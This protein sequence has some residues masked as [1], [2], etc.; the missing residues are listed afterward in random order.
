MSSEDQAESDRGKLE[1]KEQYEIRIVGSLE[2]HWQQ[3]FEGMTLRVRR[4][5]ED[6]TVYTLIAGPV[7]DQPALHGLLAAVRDLNLTLI[8]VRRLGQGSGSED[9]GDQD[10]KQDDQSSN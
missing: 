3:W 4:S 8:S 2:E 6:G 5:P 1:T 9:K 10:A 7:K